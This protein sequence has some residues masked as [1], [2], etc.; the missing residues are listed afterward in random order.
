MSSFQRVIAV[1]NLGADGELRYSGNGSPVVSF[2][3]A[4]SE[5]WKDKTSGERQ[6]KTEWIPVVYWGKPAEA[7]AQYLT[8]GTQVLVEGQLATRKWQDKD[9]KDR[10]TT[11]VKARTVQLLGSKPRRNAEPEAASDPWDGAT[12]SNAPMDEDPPF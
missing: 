8:K 10:S 5:T 11:E 9:G 2:R 12:T 6:E 7:V 4:C 3:M 1:G